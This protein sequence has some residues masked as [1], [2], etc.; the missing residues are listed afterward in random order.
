MWLPAPLFLLKEKSVIFQ[1]T[2]HF[3][4]PFRL[5]QYANRIIVF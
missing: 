3:F 5:N 4:V 2:Y 1:S